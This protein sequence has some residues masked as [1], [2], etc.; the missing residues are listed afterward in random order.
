MVFSPIAK[1]QTYQG[2]S[3]FL[4]IISV[5]LVSLLNFTIKRFCFF[6]L[7]DLSESTPSLFSINYFGLPFFVARITCLVELEGNFLIR[8]L[9][10]YI[11]FFLDSI[12][13]NFGHGLKGYCNHKLPFLSLVRFF[14]FDLSIL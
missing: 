14:R 7:G 10:L 2:C 5:S 9:F 4:R 1:L 11:Y 13:L 12:F 8:T 3:H 6:C